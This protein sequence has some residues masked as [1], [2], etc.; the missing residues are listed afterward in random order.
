[1]SNIASSI[2]IQ[3]ERIHP[4]NDLDIQPERDYVLYWMQSSQRAQENHA[5]EFAIQQANELAL[6]LVA[7][8]GV[9]DDY[10]DANARHYRF[11]LEGLQ[12]TVAWLRDRRGIQMV[13]GRG[14]PDEIAQRAAQNAALV[15]T[16]M[17]YLRPGR[18]WRAALS[19]ALD[20][21]LMQVE[22]D[23]IVPVETASNKREYAARTIRPKLH[24]QLDR[25]LV[26]LATTPLDHHS[27]DID[28]ASI[29]GA[30]L[31]LGDGERDIDAAMQQL[32]ID[33]SVAPVSHFF[34]G[35]TREAKQILSRFIDEKMGDYVENRNQPQTNN[36]SHMS[37]YLHFGHIS[38]LYVLM[39]LHEALNEN[40]IEGEQQKAYV[41][42]L[43]VRRELTMNFTHFT[44][45]YDDYACL[46]DWARKTLAEHKDDRREHVYSQEELEAAETHDDYWNAAMNEMK[47]TGYMHNYMRMYW[48][49]K[50][51]EWS[52]TPEAAHATLLAINNK[53]FLD[54]RDSNS[55]S[56]V[57]WVFGLHDRPWQERPIFGKTRYMNANGLKRKADMPA[58]IEKVQKLVEAAENA[59]D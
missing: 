41:E 39:Q 44:D 1:M 28:L 30:T 43:L 23:V 42:E 49:K 17:S 10:P 15:V 18:Q 4:L 46:P 26:E 6:P 9:T 25:F 54:G 50:V 16:D 34:R 55:F 19:S 27:V 48:G 37:K 40:E 29:V 14:R 2:V 7:A 3:D 38:P 11:M 20:C 57:A 8:F 36:V 24:R 56:N 13:I 21:R 52:E 33:Y 12:E 32:S 45:N 5:L 22:T 31:D 53:Y 47:Y 58:Y 51:L 59:G 35:G